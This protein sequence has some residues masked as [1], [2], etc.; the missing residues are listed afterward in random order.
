MRPFSFIRKDGYRRTE[1]KVVLYSL[2]LETVLVLS[3]LYLKKENILIM[4][5]KNWQIVATEQAIFMRQHLLEL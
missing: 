4:N 5:M 1:T 2:M 3:R